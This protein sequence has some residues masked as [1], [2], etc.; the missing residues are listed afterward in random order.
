[1]LFGKNEV[2]L[3]DLAKMFEAAK[4]GIVD[5]G[6]TRLG[7]KTMLDAI[8]PAV[9]AIRKAEE[10]NTSFLEAFELS[11]KAAEKG[12]RDTITMVSK[13]GRS[14]YLGERSKGHQDVGATST[15]IILKSAL[16]TLKK[17]RQENK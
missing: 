13:Q 12:M 9:V 17:L 15:Y 5:V 7:E 1:M 10:K 4:L 6:K 3:S 14:S 2:Y 16:D 11:V 8:H